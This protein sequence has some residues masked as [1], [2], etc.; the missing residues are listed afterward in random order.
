MN[1]QLDN[2]SLSEL[3]KVV[4]EALSRIYNKLREEEDFG[5]YQQG[6]ITS[7]GSESYD[8]EMMIID[9]GSATVGLDWPATWVL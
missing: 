1:E 2:M 8:V 7:L 3:S 9:T 5:Y 6:V 4:K